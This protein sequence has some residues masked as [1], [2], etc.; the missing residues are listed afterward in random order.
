MSKTT[1]TPEM[2]KKR[3]KKQSLAKTQLPFQIDGNVVN[4][5]YEA[6]QIRIQK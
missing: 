1:K 6:R 4:T 5:V 3:I 2:V